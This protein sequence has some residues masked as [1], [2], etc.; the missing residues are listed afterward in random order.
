MIL[1]LLEIMWQYAMFYS[2]CYS[3]HFIFQFSVLCQYQ[4]ECHGHH[5]EQMT[6]SIKPQLRFTQ[7]GDFSAIF[8]L[9][10]SDFSAIF[11]PFFSFFPAI[12]QLFSTKYVALTCV[13]FSKQNCN[14]K[15]CKSCY[16]SAT[17]K[18]T[19]GAGS[20]LLQNCSNLS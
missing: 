20:I 12:F 2:N 19:N 5:A 11:Q 3:T 17:G 18:L 6:R 13:K 16:S 7:T 14:K 1:C 15:Y 8:Q 10:S 9:F 4:T